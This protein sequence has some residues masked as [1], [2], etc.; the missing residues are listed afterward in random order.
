[1]AAAP[2]ICAPS[3]GSGALSPS[4]GAGRQAKVTGHGWT[5]PDRPARRRNPREREEGETSLS[6]RRK[7]P[8]QSLLDIIEHTP[9]RMA[10]RGRRRRPL[11][12]LRPLATRRGGDRPGAGAASRSSRSMRAQEKYL[13]Y[14]L[15]VITRGRCPT[16]A[17]ASSPSSAAFSSRCGSRTSRPTR[18]AASAPRSSAT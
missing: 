14:A 18:S 1:V 16:C 13:N 10:P 7:D 2:S 3:T 9:A 12:P 17:T 11:A 4:K 15:S 8:E 6:P 5:R